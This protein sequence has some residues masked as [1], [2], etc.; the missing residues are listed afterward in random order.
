MSVMRFLR[1]TIVVHVGETVEWTN[2]DPVTNHTVT[3]GIEPSNLVPPSAGVSADSDG[4]RHA[5]LGSP[6]GSVHSGFLGAARQD[7]VGLP[8]TPSGVTR[9]RATFT[10]PGTF[11][12]FCALHGKDLGM[13][14]TVIVLPAG[15]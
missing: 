5:V 7:R 1:E 11:N 9:F 12:Y 14:G 10:S 6:T 8:Q 15:E 3:F 4:A 2:L 13:L